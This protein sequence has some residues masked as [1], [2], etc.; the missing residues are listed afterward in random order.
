MIAAMKLTGG[1]DVT[2]RVDIAE[3]EEGV[4]A[5]EKATRKP[6]KSYSLLDANLSIGDTLYYANDESITAEVCSEKK[7]I[8]E[9]LRQV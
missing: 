7:V 5:L 2:P 3:D 9:V 6:R 1:K 8:F 4:R